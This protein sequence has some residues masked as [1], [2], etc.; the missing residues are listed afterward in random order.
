M[1][2]SN[3]LAAP[4]QWTVADGGNDHYY[5]VI[6]EPY[7]WI[8]AA[9]VAMNQTHQ[10]VDG[11][12]ATIT[13]VEE[14]LF[15]YDTFGSDALDHKWL[16][17]R[18]LSTASG[19]E[20]GWGWITGEQ[21]DYTNWGTGQPDD[22]LVSEERLQFDA[23]YIT[24]SEGVGWND[25]DKDLQFGYVVEYPVPEPASVTLLAIGSTLLLRRRRV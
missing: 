18:Q 8:A 25:A 19:P 4:V 13:S 22:N 9:S 2:T 20:D 23:Q 24:A 6:N 12:L 3:A 11:H 7:F 21:W 16:G 15:L 10:G 5:D 14:N 1:F 17:G